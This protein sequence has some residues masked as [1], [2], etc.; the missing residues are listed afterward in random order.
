MWLFAIFV[1]VPIVEIALF[2]QV[3]G[4][5][6][7][8]PT[9]AVV[10]L[11]AVVGSFLLR[12]QGIQTVARIRQSVATG[13]NPMNSIAHGALILIA[14]VLLLTPGFFTDVAGLSLLVPPIRVA[15]IKAG[16]SRMAT[17]VFVSNGHAHANMQSE[18]DVV[19]GDFTIIDDNTPENQRG[20][21]GWTKKPD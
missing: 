20:S 18:P 19:D 16:V 10:I 12:T 3:G 7:L 14:A 1:A 2:I 9:L 17:S 11:T 21:S 8:W 15:L 6:G 13:D 4:W 5:L